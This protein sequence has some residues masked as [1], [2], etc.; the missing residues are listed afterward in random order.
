MSKAT[1]DAYVIC[2]PLYPFISFLNVSLA[3][4]PAFSLR[5]EPQ[6]ESGLKG[7]DLGSFPI[8]SSWIKSSINAAL[9]EYLVPQYISINVLAWLNGDEVITT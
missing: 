2:S 1:L 5:I 7:F 6:S 4:I 3:E 9:S 8:V